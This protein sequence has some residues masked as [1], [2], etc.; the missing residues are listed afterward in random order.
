[1][2][3]LRQIILISI[4]IITTQIAIA[5][6]DSVTENIPKGFLNKLESKLTK[7][8]AKLNKQTLKALKRF[9]KQ[10][11]KL[12]K[13]IASKDSTFKFEDFSNYESRLLLIKKCK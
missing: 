8:E 6:S 4:S 5:Q 9:E 10:E 12:Q 1:M 3:L 13:F 2:S 7:V 11:K